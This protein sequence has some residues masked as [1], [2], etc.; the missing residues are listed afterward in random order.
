MRAVSD[1]AKLR[2]EMIFFGGECAFCEDF[3][4]L[5]RGTGCVYWQNAQKNFFA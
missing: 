3:G 1:S 2:K 5:L 4:L